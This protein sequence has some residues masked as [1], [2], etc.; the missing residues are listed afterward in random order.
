VLASYAHVQA[1]GGSICLRSLIVLF[2]AG[3]TWVFWHVLELRSLVFVLE[4]FVFVL[5]VIVVVGK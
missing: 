5:G 1:L 2:K 3:S 4:L